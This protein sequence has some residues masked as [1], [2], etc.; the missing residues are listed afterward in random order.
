MVGSK[1]PSEKQLVFVFFFFFKRLKSM[2]GVSDQGGN[3]LLWIEKL[4][5]LFLSIVLEVG[6]SGSNAS[7]SGC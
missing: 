4:K 7:L 3:G 6:N 5:R 1:L 2:M